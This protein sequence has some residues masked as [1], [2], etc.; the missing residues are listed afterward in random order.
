VKSGLE[1]IDPVD[2]GKPEDIADVI[3]DLSSDRAAFVQGAMIRAD[4]GRLERL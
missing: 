3:A 4:G 2:V 1:S